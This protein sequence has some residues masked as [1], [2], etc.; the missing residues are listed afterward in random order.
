MTEFLDGMVNGQVGLGGATF[1]SEFIRDLRGTVVKNN[2][3]AIVTIKWTVSDL[4]PIGDHRLWYRWVF[5]NNI[6]T[7][8]DVIQGNLQPYFYGTYIN[9]TDFFDTDWYLDVYYIMLALSMFWLFGY[10]FMWGWSVYLQIQYLIDC[11]SASANFFIYPGSENYTMNFWVT[12][13]WGGF[14]VWCT[15]TIMQIVNIFPFVSPPIDF[16]VVLYMY[17]SYLYQS[18]TQDRRVYY[19]TG[20]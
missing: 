1:S 10:P 6:P 14:E 16:I 2:D 19:G 12:V 18:R 3:D 20:Q 17:I 11:L 13:L 15:T 4:D 9:I 5:Y 8:S 7:Q